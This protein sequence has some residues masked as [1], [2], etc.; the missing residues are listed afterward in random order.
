MTALAVHISLLLIRI[1]LGII[2]MAHGYPKV[3]DKKAIKATS[4]F[5]KKHKV[6]HPTFFTYV[7]GFVEFFGGLFILIGFLTPIWGFLV[8]MIMIVAIALTGLDKGF[9]D[10]YELDLVLFVLGLVL[11]ILGGGAFSVS[12]ALMF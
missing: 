10:G 2:F 7:V 11:F 6:P 3:F 4:K 12:T 8:A 1:V 9:K 5:F